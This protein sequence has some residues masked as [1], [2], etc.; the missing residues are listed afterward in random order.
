MTSMIFDE[1]LA[2]WGYNSSGYSLASPTGGVTSVTTSDLAVPTTSFTVVPFLAPNLDFPFTVTGEM[3]VAAS[4]A[5]ASLR[6]GASADSVTGGDGNDEVY[7]AGGSDKVDGGGG[8]DLV[9]GGS[10]VISPDDTADTILGGNGGDEM[11]GNGGDDVIVG[12][13]GVTDGAGDGNDTMVGGLGNDQLYGNGGADFIYGLN[14]DDI[15][16]GG[17]GD[18]LLVFSFANDD[19][20]VVGFE[21][22][23]I[24]GG[25]LIAIDAGLF[26]SAADVVANILYA[27]GA[28]YISFGSNGSVTF[29]DV[30][31]NSITADD[32]TIFDGLSLV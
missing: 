2:D 30:A 23:G 20:L 29:A 22:A 1:W 9:Y 25:D 10:G 27:S 8:R 18:D 11:Y 5:D 7:G 19:D 16:V 14:G 12:D 32:I 28:A 4:A 26:S 15:I 3:L 6:G 17:G 13:T 24:A 21:G 31:A